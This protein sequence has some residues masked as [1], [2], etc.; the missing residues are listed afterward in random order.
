[1][2]LYI[3]IATLSAFQG[4]TSKL[5]FQLRLVTLMVTC[6]NVFHLGSS[7]LGYNPA[8]NAPVS[9]YICHW[10]N[11]VTFGPWFAMQSS[12]MDEYSDHERCRYCTTVY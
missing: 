1:M 12:I 8:L 11:I 2:G 4:L 9:P 10:P 7:V 6:Q 3:T 5:Q